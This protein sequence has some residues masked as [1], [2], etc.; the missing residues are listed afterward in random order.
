[1]HPCIVYNPHGFPPIFTPF[2]VGLLLDHSHHNLGLGICQD[3]FIKG[4]LHVL[5]NEDARTQRTLEG[6]VRKEY[7]VG[8]E[9]QTSNNTKVQVS[10]R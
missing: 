1:M 8:K 2:L 10:N 5:V 4:C 3:W 7:V 9:G 6:L